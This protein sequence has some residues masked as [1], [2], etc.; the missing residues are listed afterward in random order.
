MKK[1]ILLIATGGTIASAEGA[2]GLAPSLSGEDLTACVPE[3]RD[4][5]DLAVLQLMN[6][7]SSNVRPRHWLAMS[8]AIAER[9]ADYDGFV[10][11][12]GTDTMSYTAAALSYLIQQSAKPIVLTGSQLPM[13][14]PLTDARKNLCE[15]VLYA[16]DD[17]SCDVSVV[18]DGIAIAGTRARKQRTR[19]L[20][21]FESVNF[22][23]LARIGNGRIARMLPPP[24]FSPGQLRIF[25]RLNERVFALKLLP[26]TTAHI[27]PL[28]EADYDAVVLESFGIGGIPD[29]DGSFERAIR[30]WTASGRLLAVTTQVPEE[31]CD[32]R[33]YEVGSKYHGQPGIL[34][35]GTMTP[36]AAA[37]K[38]MWAMAQ[39]TAPAPLF[40]HPINFDLSIQ[41]CGK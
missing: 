32:L 11:T 33:V 34:E 28:L 14:A 36:E 19:S 10:L 17:A 3:L 40:H 15:S 25:D 7:D 12:H 13:T 37:A 20:H 18:F 31:G 8:R 1:K 23:P 38:L 6:L 41:P 9:Y 22:P 29:E 35:T 26:S 30:R 16:A 39:N 4:L 27:F 21:A 2:D 5:C 24:D